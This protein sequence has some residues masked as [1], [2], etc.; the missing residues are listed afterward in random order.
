MGNTK[1]VKVV[2]VS[3]VPTYPANLHQLQALYDW[4]AD[5]TKLGSGVTGVLAEIEPLSVILVRNPQNRYDRNAIE[6]HVPALGDEAMIGHIARDQAAII[7]PMMD[8]GRRFQAH[9]H[10]CRVLESQPQN[11]GIDI[12]I[13][14]IMEGP[15]DEYE[16]G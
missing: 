10:R 2:G 13:T 15:T 8:R 14:R 4:Q 16:S 3:F 1:I 9:V 7:A 11:P 5:Q 12:S 6:V